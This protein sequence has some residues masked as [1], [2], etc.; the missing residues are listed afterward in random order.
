MEIWRKKSPA[1]LDDAIA[2]EDEGWQVFAE[3]K[4][5]SSGSITSVSF[6]E[7]ESGSTGFVLQHPYEASFSEK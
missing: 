1:L 3:G 2:R 5:M 6:A 7:D 4:D